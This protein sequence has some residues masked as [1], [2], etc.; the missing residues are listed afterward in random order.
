MSLLPSPH[1]TH[2][3]LTLHMT[4][5]ESSGVFKNLTPLNNSL[6]KISGILEGGGGG[7][8]P[9]PPQIPKV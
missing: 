9:P 8:T 6:L 4:A 3:V 5:L 1:V 7:A 2:T